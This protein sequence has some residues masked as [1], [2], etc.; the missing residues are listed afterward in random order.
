[1]HRHVAADPKEAA[2]AA[3]RFIAARLSQALEGNEMATL[4]VSGGSTPKLMFDSLVGE[5]VEWERV[6]LFWVDERAVPPNDP[7]SNYAMT[8]RHL[9][10]PARLP[11]RNVRR[12]HAERGPQA[13]ASEYVA[14][15]RAAFR[16]EQGQLPHF[17]VIQLGIGAD[18]HTASL[19]PGDPLIEDRTHIA[20]ATYAEKL[21]KWRITLLPGVLLS[22]HH[23]V[24]LATGLD[25]ARAL[26][27]VLSGEYDPLA[28]PAQI[29]THHGR[30][31]H[32]FMDAASA[33][34]LD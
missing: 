14:A 12:I 30:S 33:A 25:K 26:Q 29:L 20:A 13:A 16:L 8:E 2:S 10:V 24:V 23:S 17:D 22:A 27:R 19:F 18:A 11:K 5:A 28:V 6:Q 4:A 31:V 21:D 15:I 34:K 9:I 7:E 3:A 32:W 1:M